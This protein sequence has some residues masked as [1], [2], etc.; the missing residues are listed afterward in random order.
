MEAAF[1][2]AVPSHP[3]SLMLSRSSTSLAKM[4]L[5][6]VTCISK[7]HHVAFLRL[8]SRDAENMH[9]WVFFDSMSDMQKGHRIPILF[10]VPGLANYFLHGYDP[11]CLRIQQDASGRDNFILRLRNH[12]FLSLY[13]RQS[14]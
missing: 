8:P 11:S 1:A 7:S 4:E 9:R 2:G 14:E 6:A 10:E 3:K 13:T 5:T 12:A